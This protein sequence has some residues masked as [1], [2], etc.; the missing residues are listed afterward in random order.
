M[1]TFRPLFC[2][3]EPVQIGKLTRDIISNFLNK[4][5]D[6]ILALKGNQG[7]FYEN[8]TSDMKENGQGTDSRIEEYFDESHEK[9]V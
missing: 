6:Y 9:V 1:Y 3:L 7:K 2:L 4:D 5:A 8:I